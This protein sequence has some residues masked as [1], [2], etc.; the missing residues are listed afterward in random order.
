MMRLLVVTGNSIEGILRTDG[1]RVLRMEQTQPDGDKCRAIEYAFRQAGRRHA[2]SRGHI[3]HGG[4][5]WAESPG[6]GRG[7]TFH[8][9]L[10]IE[11]PSPDD[12]R[13]FDGWRSDGEHSA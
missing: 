3:V 5:I 4:R 1:W 2:G 7:A 12:P 10:P 6:E 8:V 9:T 13:H 11:L